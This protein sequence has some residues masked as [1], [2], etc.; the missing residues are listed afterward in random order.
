MERKPPRIVEHAL[1]MSFKGKFPPDVSLLSSLGFD[2]ISVSRRE[3]SIKKSQGA[4]FAGQPYLFHQIVLRKNM[5]LLRYSVADGTDEDIRRLHATCAL[6]RVLSLFPKMQQ[7]DAAG[8][9]AMVLPPLEASAEVAGTGYELLSKKYSD[10]KNDFTELS[11]KNKRLAAAAEEGAVASIELER[12]ISAL[13]VR[14]QKLETVSDAVLCEM[15]LDWLNSHRGSFDAVG[16]SKSTGVQPQRAEE[17]L[18]MLAKSGAVR[19][20]GS[21]YAAG[22][23]DGRGIY[24]PRKAGALVPAE[25][26]EELGKLFSFMKK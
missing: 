8:L 15:V 18:E 25:K 10:L 5:V 7:A 12:Q 16:F 17:G 2:S 19:K 21:G 22:R 11:L 14:V 1:P 13:C 23:H 4:D 3:V 20:L 26:L 6:L 24:E 9:A